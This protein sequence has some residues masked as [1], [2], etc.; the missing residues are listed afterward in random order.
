MNYQPLPQVHGNIPVFTEIVK[1][2]S[3]R[4]KHDKGSIGYMIGMMNHQSIVS[5]YWDSYKRSELLEVFI[6]LAS[7]PKVEKLNNG[8]CLSEVFSKFQ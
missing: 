7:T 3:N 5:L 6:N 4:K 2:V 1:A 8:Y